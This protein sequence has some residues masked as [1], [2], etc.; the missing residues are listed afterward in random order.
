LLV[1]VIGLKLLVDWGFNSEAHPHTIDFHSVH[2]PEFWV[3]WIS[4]IACLAVGFVPKR[5]VN[6]ESVDG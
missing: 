6:N 4:M 5:R 1:I 2:R 3:F